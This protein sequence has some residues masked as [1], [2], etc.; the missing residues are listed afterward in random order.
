MKTLNQK[1][2]QAI[3]KASTPGKAKYMGRRVALRSDWEEVKT[4]VMELGL[5]LK[6][7][8]TTLAE[9]LLATN[10]EELVE[11]NWWHDNIWG[12]CMCDKCIHITGQ[13]M[14]GILLMDLRKK[15]RY[16]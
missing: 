9:K 5:Q 1:E 14:L 10:D 4:K 15:M 12:S 11:G 8:D 3:A 2:R 7:T 6:F 16:E 13:N